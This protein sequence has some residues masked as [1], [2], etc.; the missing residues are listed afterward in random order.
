MND[1][2]RL[3]SVI[4]PTRLELLVLIFVLSCAYLCIIHFHNC[5]FA[6]NVSAQLHFCL[7]LCKTFSPKRTVV[8][9]DLNTVGCF[10]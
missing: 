7:S 6:D 8:K 4:V 2:G 5:H 10:Y 3:W 1:I 9:R